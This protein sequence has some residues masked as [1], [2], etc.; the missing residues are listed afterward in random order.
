MTDIIWTGLSL[1]ALLAA[2]PALVLA[3]V[4]RRPDRT[5]PPFQV[6]AAVQTG[7]TGTGVPYVHG[8][9]TTRGTA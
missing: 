4:L 2:Y 7:T 9:T 8:P 6:P 1:V 3:D 5:P